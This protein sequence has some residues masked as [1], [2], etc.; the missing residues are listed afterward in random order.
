MSGRRARGDFK[1]FIK[2]G[3][4]SRSRLLS[5]A[6][7]VVGGGGDFHLRA[8]CCVLAG[9][10]VLGV[11][12]VRLLACPA[13]RRLVHDELLAY[14]LELSSDHSSIEMESRQ[15][16]GIS[17]RPESSPAA[18]RE[19]PPSPVVARE[20]LPSPAAAREELPLLAAATDEPGRSPLVEAEPRKDVRVGGR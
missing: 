18:A 4:L 2:V 1:L 11:D 14:N 19:V 8:E 17:G 7:L 10:G 16:E 6:A 20:E 12:C 9:L 3:D 5:L 15:I 13:D